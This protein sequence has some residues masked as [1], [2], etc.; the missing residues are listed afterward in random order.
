MKIKIRHI[1]FLVFIL[2]AFDSISFSQDTLHWRHVLN[3]FDIYKP[4]SWTGINHCDSL[5]CAVYDYDAGGIVMNS[6]DGGFSW[7]Y[8]LKEPFGKK[9][10]VEGY[11]Y[12]TPEIMII[13]YYQDS[14][15]IRTFNG[16]HS[17]DTI[18]N[19]LGKP[20]TE[21]SFLK[22]GTGI[23][24]QFDTVIVFPDDTI[25]P[26]YGFQSFIFTKDFGKTWSKLPSEPS[27][28]GYERPKIFSEHIFGCFGYFRNDTLSYFFRS[29]D[30]GKTW[31]KY[32]FY[33]Y[34]VSDIF[35]I[36]SLKG[37]AVIENNDYSDR[38]AFTEN[39]GKSWELQL[40][41]TSGTFNGLRSI[42]FA[43]SLN[44]VACGYD[45]KILRTKDGGKTWVKDTNNLIQTIGSSGFFT[46]VTCM[47]PKRYLIATFHEVY[48]Y[49]EDGFPND[50]K[51]EIKDKNQLLIS[52][53]PAYNNINIRTNL[54]EPCQLRLEI[55]N[56]FG[57]S[58]LP[59]I[60]EFADAGIYSRQFDLSGIAPGLYFVVVRTC[61]ER[62]VQKFVKF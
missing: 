53:N 6:D 14:I 12:L 10:Q 4:I 32:P 52:P 51:E 13:N 55:L 39:G 19:N 50:V 28:E 60:N 8:Y 44:G 2:F 58:I 40:D 34:Y 62:Y 23:G 18:K 29:E 21:Y 22:D 20:I 9:G 11:E 27:T 49:D 15:L 1:S 35:F 47:T 59:S 33:S 7:K 37:W 36:D 5:H 54:N 17:F 61:K 24:I 43:D 26:Y 25:N 41:D 57:Q 56:T 31:D 3:S 38:I 45:A 30:G 42:S 16:G 46:Y 48:M